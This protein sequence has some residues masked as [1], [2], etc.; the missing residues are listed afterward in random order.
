MI[1]IGN[2]LTIINDS[3]RKQSKYRDVV[4]ITRSYYRLAKYLTIK[5]L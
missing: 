4:K 1:K 3:V 2:V 5:T